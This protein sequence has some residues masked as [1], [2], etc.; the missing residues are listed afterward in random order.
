M[1]G[2]AIVI[3]APANQMPDTQVIAKTKEFC[4]DLAIVTLSFGTMQADLN[5]IRCLK[6]SIP[7]LL[8]G[9]R[10][11]P[12][13]VWCDELLNEN[14][15]ITF[16]LSGD[17][18]LCIADLLGDAINPRGV[19]RKIGGQVLKVPPAYAS[20]LDDLPNADRSS[21]NKEKYL[22]RF[23]G[24]PQ[25]TV[26]VQRGCP[27]PCAYCLVHTVSGSIARHRSPEHIA[28]EILELQEAG[29]KY[30]YLRAETFSVNQRWALK[31]CQ[32]LSAK[33]PGINWVT[34]NRVECV[35]EELLSA[36]KK[37]GC[38]GVSFG[39]DVGSELIASKV[40]KPLNLKAAEQ[41]MRLCDKVGI[42][43]LAYIMIGFIWDT[44][45]TLRETK[46][47]I[48][49]LSPDLV[50]VHYAHPYPGTDYYNTIQNELLS[51]KIDA[52]GAQAKPALALPTMSV[53]ELNRWGKAIL[54]SHYS[55]PRSLFSLTK[56]LLSFAIRAAL[57]RRENSSPTPLQILFDQR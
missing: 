26:R 14:S 56:K 57:G 20:N 51:I 16:S 22:V 44:E 46:D 17:Y 5:F 45:E 29:Y 43:S 41:A 3:D 32:V 28:A 35:D 10:G 30:F 25:A 18:E 48:R 21:I 24:Q 50:T 7:D 39:V 36:M 37:A 27:F 53:A 34:T 1:G 23:S 49:R 8:I 52:G 6:R 11:A 33:C 40:N 55:R 12:C 2:A 4:A 42:V 19:S 9:V 13:Y 15:E 54:R 38:Y 31:L 47:F